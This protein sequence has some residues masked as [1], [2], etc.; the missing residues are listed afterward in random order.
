MIDNQKFPKQHAHLQAEELSLEITSLNEQP[1][2]LNLI[3]E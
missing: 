2:R 3:T 1:K